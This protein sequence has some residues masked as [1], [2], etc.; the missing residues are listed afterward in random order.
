MA[1]RKEATGGFGPPGGG[2]PQPPDLRTFA[3][4]RTA[5]VAAQ[6]AGTSKGYVPAGFGFG[7]PPAGGGGAFGRAPS[8]PIDEKTFRDTVP[9]VRRALPPGPGDAVPRSRQVSRQTGNC[10]W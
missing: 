2:A 1:G 7:R 4:K 8:Q 6:L 5:S 9:E 3:Q 10:S